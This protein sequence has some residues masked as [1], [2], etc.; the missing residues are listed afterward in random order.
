MLPQESPTDLRLVRKKPLSIVADSSSTAL[1]KALFC[2]PAL[3]PSTLPA[4]NSPRC[5]L[6]GEIPWN[7]EQVFQGITWPR[8]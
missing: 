2:P 5:T 4:Q 7:T 1:F 8:G 6:Q 3:V